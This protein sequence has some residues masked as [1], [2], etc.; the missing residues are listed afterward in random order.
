MTPTHVDRGR[1]SYAFHTISFLGCVGQVHYTSPSLGRLISSLGDTSTSLGH[2]AG[3]SPRLDHATATTS[4]DAFML[5]TELVD[6]TSRRRKLASLWIV[7]HQL[8]SPRRAGYCRS[9]M[10]LARLVSTSV[11]RHYRLERSSSGYDRPLHWQPKRIAGLANSGRCAEAAVSLSKS[12]GYGI[13]V[14]DSVSSASDS[15]GYGILVLYSVA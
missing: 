7:T 11:G 12:V 3:S 5:N 15:V 6:W 4:I 9:A 8:S 1:R 13:L 2:W 14:L 10:D